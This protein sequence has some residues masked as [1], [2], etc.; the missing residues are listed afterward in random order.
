M[1]KFAI[2]MIALLGTTQA[3]KIQARDEGDEDYDCVAEDGEE[4]GKFLKWINKWGKNYTGDGEWQEKLSNWISNNGM[5]KW[6]NW[7]AKQ[8]GNPDAATYDHNEFSDKNHD[9]LQKHLGHINVDTGD[10]GTQLA[11]S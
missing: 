9:E 7:K 4:T 1:K 10:D 3:L 6:H 11:Q 8:S 5:I 2:A